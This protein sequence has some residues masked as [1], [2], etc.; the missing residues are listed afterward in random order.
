MD[1]EKRTVTTYYVELDS[2]DLST[3]L[4]IFDRYVASCE[5]F[6]NGKDEFPKQVGLVNQFR[7]VSGLSRYGDNY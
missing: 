3:L 2:E 7:R 1:I 5:V 4:D 6:P